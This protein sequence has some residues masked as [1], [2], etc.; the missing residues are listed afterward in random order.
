MNRS[1]VSATPGALRARRDHSMDRQAKGT[2]EMGRQCSMAVSINRPLN[3]H[4]PPRAVAR[5]K[6]VRKPNKK[7]PIRLPRV[8]KFLDGRAKGESLWLFL[9]VQG[10]EA[11]H[12]IAERA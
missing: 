1:S 2:H 9:D 12:N 3:R 10:V 5:L 11:T 4:S 6:N 7:T 8:Q